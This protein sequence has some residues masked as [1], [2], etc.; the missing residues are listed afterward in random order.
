M[1]LLNVRHFDNDGKHKML[2]ILSSYWI[3]VIENMQVA[4]E[5]FY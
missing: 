1:L 2:I 4:I 5:W 3:Y